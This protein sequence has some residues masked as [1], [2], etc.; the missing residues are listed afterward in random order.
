MKK[1]YTFILDDSDVPSSE[2]DN[3]LRIMAYIVHE[4]IRRIDYGSEKPIL[5]SNKL[6]KNNDLLEKYKDG[7]MVY[8]LL[9]EKEND[10]KIE[11][12]SGIFNGE[13]GR[14]TRNK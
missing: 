2:I 4:K 3:I 5:V 13:I 7:H 11:A 9:S 14:I 1:I 6:L 8:S 12:G 10:D